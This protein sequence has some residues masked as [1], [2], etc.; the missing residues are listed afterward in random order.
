MNLRKDHYRFSKLF[1]NHSWQGLKNRGDRSVASPCSNFLSDA[2]CRKVGVPGSG[3]SSGKVPS[4]GEHPAACLRRPRGSKSSPPERG[5]C[6]PV[7][8]L[9]FGFFPFTVCQISFGRMTGPL[10]LPVAASPGH[11]TLKKI[12]TLSGGSLGSRVDEE[13]SQ[14]RELM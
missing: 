4:R 9:V 14:L 1:E 7:L 2:F 10:A 12:K 13:R 8:L 3:T 5:V 11:E 6:R